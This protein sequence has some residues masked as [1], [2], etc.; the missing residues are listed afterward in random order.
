M[1]VRL[2]QPKH[3]SKFMPCDLAV[4]H[5]FTRRDY[6]RVCFVQGRVF[7]NDSP[8]FAWF[9]FAVEMDTRAKCRQP[10]DEQHS[11]K[12]RSHDQVSFIKAV[13]FLFPYYIVVA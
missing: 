6:R 8:E 5:D 1:I 10:A 3:L 4:C 9:D 2:N 11:R 13:L 7:L 12:Y